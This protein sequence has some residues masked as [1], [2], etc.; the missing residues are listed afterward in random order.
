MDRGGEWIVSLLRF[1]FVLLS[2]FYKFKLDFYL[3]CFDCSIVRD[4][5]LLETDLKKIIMEIEFKLEVHNA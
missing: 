1:C 3:T 4:R 2:Y 5:I